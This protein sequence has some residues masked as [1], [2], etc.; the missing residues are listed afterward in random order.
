MLLLPLHFVGTTHYEYF[1]FLLVPTTMIV[2]VGLEKM[3][4]RCHGDQPAPPGS[5]RDRTRGGEVLPTPPPPQR[6][7]T[8]ACRSP[9]SQ[10]AQRW[11]GARHQKERRDAK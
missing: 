6:A 3:R 7:A 10:G 9:T 4:A 5:E 8:A 1:L 2:G 11:K